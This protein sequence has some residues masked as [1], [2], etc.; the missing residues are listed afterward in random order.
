MR[1]PDAYQ[2][3]VKLLEIYNQLQRD[4]KGIEQPS[5]LAPTASIGEGCYVGAFA[6]VGNN[7]RIGKNVKIYPQVYI[8]DNVVIGD[9]TTLLPVPVSIPTV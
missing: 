1:V 8:G 6:Y 7:A 5:F 3:F 2:A 9:N 4:K